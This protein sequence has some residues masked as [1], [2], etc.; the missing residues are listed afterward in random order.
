[1]KK[2]ILFLTACILSACSEDKEVQAFD[3]SDNYI[4]EMALT[5]GDQTFPLNISGEEIFLTFP[6]E[7]SL[8]EASAAYRISEQATIAP[9]P[10]AISDWSEDQ[11]FTVTAYNGTQRT[12]T[13]SPEV[14]ENI[15]SG[16]I[17]LAD[18]TQVDRFGVSGVRKIAGNLVIGSDDAEADPIESLENLAGLVSVE[19]D[20]KIL[21]SCARAEL[22]A[23]SALER[24]GSLHIG[25]AD[26][27]FTSKEATEIELPAL[28]KV[29]G[30]ISIR[31]PY[32][33]R[34]SLPVLNYVGGMI[35]IASGSL[36]D[37][38]L[39]KLEG[40]IMGLNLEHISGGT[41]S[42][43]TELVFPLLEESSDFSISGFKTLATISAPALKY[44]GAFS[45]TASSGK[46]ESLD[47]PQLETVDGN[48]IVTGS[49]A[50][51]TF[52][53]LKT[54]A[55]ANGTMTLTDLTALTKFE[56]PTLQTLHAASIT[57]KSSPALTELNF[58]S[59]TSL[60]DLSVELSD[61]KITALRIVG[62][63]R[64]EGSVSLNITVSNKVMTEFKF[65]GFREIAKNFTFKGLNYYLTPIE[66]STIEVVGGRLYTTTDGYYK[67]GYENQGL[68]FG[69][70]R[71][72]GDLILESPNYLNL[73][74]CPK[75]KKVVNQLVLD[76]GVCADPVLEFPLLEEI[77][78]DEDV[79]YMY[80]HGTAKTEITSHLHLHIPE[81]NQN[82]EMPSLKRVNGA[83][84]LDNYWNLCSISMPQLEHVSRNLTIDGST[85]FTPLHLTSL[86]FSKLS[87][88]GG[89]ITIQNAKALEDFSSFKTVIGHITEEQWEITDCAY[90]PTFAQMQAGKYTPEEDAQP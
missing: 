82:F 87:S 58:A 88:L 61:K 80:D 69:N 71:Q 43:V 33:Q 37:M 89:K 40:G 15:P 65:E 10:A 6:A 11:S 84:E 74:S 63:D 72:T 90:N 57:L 81:P 42:T 76:I 64:V 8:T 3:G 20:V 54:L 70:L 30:N 24:I 46:L 32:M 55:A 2:I 18:Q 56:I 29:S 9:D 19:G 31:A 79:Y 7:T 47:L 49:A 50:L 78:S 36:A 59:C 75:L 67:D 38:N 85:P 23:L 86:N 35:Q 13:Y 62:P 16:T 25:T 21:N 14:A 39:P 66:L 5:V 28:A 52:D 48:F 45:Y 22:S 34:L 44:L 53:G 12:Y 17:V 51:N 26:A 83:I 73:I 27:A 77:G 1:M 68:I 60:G 41:G 4:L